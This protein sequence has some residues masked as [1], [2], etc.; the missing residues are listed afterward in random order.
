[1][2]DKP[3]D[4]PP[5]PPTQP[6]RPLKGKLKKHEKV[7]ANATLDDYNR[8]LKQKNLLERQIEHTEYNRLRICKLLKGMLKGESWEEIHEAV[9]YLI[10]RNKNLSEGKPAQKTF[11][12][13]LESIPETK[14]FYTVAEASKLLNISHAGIKTLL[15]YKA[16]KGQMI[17]SSVPRITKDALIS[18]AAK[19]EI[20]I[21]WKN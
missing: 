13:N 16:L 17:N 7:L 3:E 18:F 20:E 1:M 9:S 15:R 2:P 12:P 8:L 11:E 4:L 14:M 6:L 10:I 5:P 19:H 21:E